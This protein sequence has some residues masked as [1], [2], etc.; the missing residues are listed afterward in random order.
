[1][2]YLGEQWTF[3]ETPRNFNI[4]PGGE[5]MYVA[6]QNTDNIVTFKIDKAAGKLE[7]SGKMLTSG[8][9][10]CILFHTPA[11][12]GNT[13]RDGV[14]FHAISNPCF[15]DSTGLGQTTFAWNAPGAVEIRIGAPDGPSMGRQAAYGTQS[16]GR[17]VTDGM[18]FY[19]QEA[20]RPATAENTL[21]TA[22]VAVQK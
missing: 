19:L 16:T 2:T 18:T 22:R 17:W 21:G 8:Q 14:T 4:A 11:A 12:P 1:M 15:A 9:P 20:D 3:G 5:Y 13:V 7:F 6:H 10:V